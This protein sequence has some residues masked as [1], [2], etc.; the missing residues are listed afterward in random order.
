MKPFDRENII[1]YAKSTGHILTAEEHSIYNGL[2]SRVAEVVSE[3]YPV[4]VVRIGMRDTFGKSG[5]SWELFD[6]FHMGIK[7]IVDAG[8]KCF[9]EEDKYETVS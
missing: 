4:S 9:L 7:D 3:E 2:G 8:V 5:K 1:K 6:Y